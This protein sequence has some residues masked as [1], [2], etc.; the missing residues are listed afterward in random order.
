M[1]IPSFFHPDLCESDINVDL[2]PEEAAHALKSR[3]LKVGQPVRL[4]NGRGLVGIGRLQIVDKR[5]AAISMSEF[6]LHDRPAQQ[7]TVAAAV[8]KGDR[9]KV[10][11]DMLTQSGCAKIVPIQYE[12]SVTKF[13]DK[14]RV[15]WQRTVIE[16]C[17]QSQ[18]PWV[19]EVADSQTVDELL[20]CSS[21]PTMYADA[22]G[23]S[24]RDCLLHPPVATV[25][26]GPEG[27]FSPQ[28]YDCFRAK[29]LIAVKLGPHILRTEAAAVVAAAQWVQ[30]FSA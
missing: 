28:E 18:N 10:M 26:I 19:P 8:P 13:S 24:M 25:L 3:R 2:K 1:A 12:Y 5:R 30:L 17:K 6:T 20:A 23:A 14:L 4:L 21:G 27:G 11:L 15:K 9:Q 7:L 22:E 29:G 16:S